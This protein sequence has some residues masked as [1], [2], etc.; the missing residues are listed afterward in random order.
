M[1]RLG[2]FLVIRVSLKGIMKD[3]LTSR[4]LKKNLRNWVTISE[5]F[6]KTTSN[7]KFNTKK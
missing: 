3:Q 4:K 5:K 6:I 1:T 7:P 2:L